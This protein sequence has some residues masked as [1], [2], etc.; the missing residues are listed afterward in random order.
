MCDWCRSVS[1][2]NLHRQFTGNSAWGYFTSYAWHKW[3]RCSMLCF[4]FSP[5]RLEITCTPFRSNQIWSSPALS[6]LCLSRQ[7]SLSTKRCAGLAGL[8]AWIEIEW[9]TQTEL[10]QD[11]IKNEKK[12]GPALGQVA[13]KNAPI[14]MQWF[15]ER[16]F[17][18]WLKHPRAISVHL[19]RCRWRS[20]VCESD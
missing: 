5:L 6:S 4:D 15:R 7:D 13:L 14:A 18:S 1:W 3:T 11:Q 12:T 9:I 17:S 19:P 16:S 8:P 2:R 20:V 10:G